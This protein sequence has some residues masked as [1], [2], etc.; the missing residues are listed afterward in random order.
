MSTPDKNKNERH[1]GPGRGAYDEAQKGIRER[2]DE[3]RRVAKK[4]KADDEHRA[5]VGRNQR[6]ARDG[7]Y[8]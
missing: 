8:R 1:Q 4:Q 3:A 5:Q 6:D 2:N 7:V